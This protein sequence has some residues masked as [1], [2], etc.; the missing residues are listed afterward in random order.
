MIPAYQ[1]M[2]FSGRHPKTTT[3][4]LNLSVIRRKGESQNRCFKK[5]RHAKFSAKRTFVFRK[6]WR[7]LFSWNTR[8]E[9][10]P[11]LPYY[12]RIYTI[13]RDQDIKIAYKN[14]SNIFK[15]LQDR[16]ILATMHSVVATVFTSPF[17]RSPTCVKTSEMVKS[18]IITFPCLREEKGN[19]VSVFSII[20]KNFKKNSCAAM[21]RFSLEVEG[22]KKF[23]KFSLIHLSP[24]LLFKKFTILRLNVVWISFTN[25]TEFCRSNSKVNNDALLLFS[26][27][28]SFK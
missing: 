11:F 2:F 22:W 9:I 23:T 14:T 18:L 3:C 26:Y 12:L 1:I 25:F 27:P 28:L 10:R 19:H 6:I 21:V 20:L 15:E 17:N 16:L 5:T 7:V 4:L 8:F 13:F 24:K